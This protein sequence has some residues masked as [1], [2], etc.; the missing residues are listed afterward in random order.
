MNQWSDGFESV[1][2]LKITPAGQI[3]EFYNAGFWVA[4]LH[5]DAHGNLIALSHK[6]GLIST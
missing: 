2:I 6:L 5:V 4:G 1:P 3:E